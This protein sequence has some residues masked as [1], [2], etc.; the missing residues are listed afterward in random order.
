MSGFNASFPFYYSSFP[1]SKSAAC[2]PAVISVAETGEPVTVQG[3][4]DI[5]VVGKK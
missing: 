2:M 4:L 3:C 5:R 1:K